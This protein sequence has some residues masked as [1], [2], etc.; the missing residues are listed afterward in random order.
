MKWIINEELNVKHKASVRNKTILYTKYD[1]LLHRDIVI[2]S[3]L[4]T[5]K[6]RCNFII[7]TH[8]NIYVHVMTFKLC[9]HQEIDFI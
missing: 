5:M 7:I 6:L 1:I 8:E 2:Q 9:T 3:T 4:I